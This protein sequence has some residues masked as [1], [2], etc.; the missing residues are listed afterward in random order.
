MTGLLQQKS[1]LFLLL[2]VLRT[3]LG[4][5]LFLALSGLGLRSTHLGSGKLRISSTSD[6]YVYDEHNT[7]HNE[8]AVLLEEGGSGHGQIA[9]SFQHDQVLT[10]VSHDRQFKVILRVDENLERVTSEVASIGNLRI[11]RNT[12][13]YIGVVL[14]EDLEVKIHTVKGIH[15]VGNNNTIDSGLVLHVQRERLLRLGLVRRLVDELKQHG[16]G[17]IHRHVVDFHSHHL[18]RLLLVHR[19]LLA[20]DLPRSAEVAVHGEVEVSGRGTECHSYDT[21]SNQGKRS[22]YRVLRK[23]VSVSSSLIPRGMFDFCMNGWMP[24]AKRG[25]VCRD[26]VSGLFDGNKER[27]YVL[28]MMW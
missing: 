1:I 17:G 4:F 26:S 28:K 13:R 23:S 5:S 9:G 10:L 19:Q 22:H 18:G 8:I 25:L 14:H 20:L 11:K 6:P 7:H 2:L 16:I 12:I 3:L 27:N 24:L 15:L 21:Q